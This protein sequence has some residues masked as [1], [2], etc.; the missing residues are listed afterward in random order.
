MTR[1]KFTSKFK[2]KVV[3]E[4]LKERSSL[5]ELAQKYELQPTQISAWKREF[6]EGATQV[7]DSGKSS[8]KSEAEQEKDKLLKTIGKLKVE[9]DFLKDALR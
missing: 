1:R 2:T 3:L 6:L 5:A 9:N 8:K 7:F 4:A